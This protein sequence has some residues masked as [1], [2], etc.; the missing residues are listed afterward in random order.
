MKR[1]NFKGQGASHGNHKQP[2]R[3]RLDRRLRHPGARL[4]G[5]PHGRPDGRQQVTTLNLEV[6][7]PTPSAS[8]S[9]SR[10]PCPGPGAASSCCATRSR[11][12]ARREVAM[13]T[14]TAP[15]ARRRAT[16]PRSVPRRSPAPH[17]PQRGGHELGH[18]R[19]RAGESSASSPTAPC[20]PGRHGP[21]GRRPARA[22]S[23]PRP[24]P[25]S[26]GGGGQAVPPEGHRPGPPGL[27]PL[28]AMSGG[29]V[30]LGPK[31]RGYAQRT[32]RRWSAWPCCSALS[33]PGRRSGAVGAR[34][35]LEDGGAEDQ[36]RRRR[37]AQARAGRPGAGRARPTRTTSP[38]ARSPTCPRSQTMPGDQLSAHDV[39]APT[40][41]V[42]TD[43]TLP[44]ARPSRRGDRPRP[45][46]QPRRR[47]GGHRRRPPA[48]QA[49]ERARRTADRTSGSGEKT[50]IR[51]DVS[52][53]P[54]GVREALR[55]HGPRA[56][57]S[58]SSIPGP[59]RST[60]ATPSSRPSAC[61]STK[62][63]HAQPQGQGDAQ[64]A[65]QHSGSGPTPSGPS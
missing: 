20:S 19:P 11:P 14:A 16:V 29:G 21:A 65:D 39:L 22:P 52:H 28:A 49:T 42:F 51:D 5:H 15:S 36:G 63:Q 48:A 59:P 58:S 12:R 62:R 24:G 40:G 34:R 60:S 27:E 56:S 1:H 53:P 32:P 61:G 6:V 35:R 38:T 46:P 9:W 18:G 23:R 55:A 4:Q 31:P 44:R 41:V 57:T 64:P 45:K 43:D 3:T 10:A 26:A 17:R 33:R 25:R 47:A 8:W 30:A 37:A 54:G 13:T 7:R 2:P 50:T